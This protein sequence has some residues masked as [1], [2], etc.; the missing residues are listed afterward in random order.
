MLCVSDR[1]VT[2]HVCAAVAGLCLKPP[3]S[4]CRLAMHGLPSLISAL[5]PA[6]TIRSQAQSQPVPDAQTQVAA[7]AL[8]LL[9]EAVLI[10]T[11]CLREGE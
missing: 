4:S 5:A 8:T 6:A 11:T 2:S 7:A 9:V 1:H 10:S 3:V